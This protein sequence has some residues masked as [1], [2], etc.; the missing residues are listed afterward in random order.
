MTVW[1]TQL[2]R[3]IGLTLVLFAWAPAAR[4]DDGLPAHSTANPAQIR[5][6]AEAAEKAGD[7]EAAFAAYCQLFVT[8]RSLEVRER[9]NT[10]L[11]RVQQ[12][13]RHRDP[14]FARFVETLPVGDAL[15]L[16]AEMATK[17]PVMHA[18][19][20]RSAPQQ[21][22]EN[23]IEELDRALGS[24]AFRFGFLDAPSTVKVEAFRTSLRTHWSKR[25]VT[26]AKDAKHALRQLLA[27]A[28]DTFPLRL[29][30]A[31]AVEVL[32]GAC[33]GLDEYSVFLTPGQFHADP[34]AVVD[35]TAHGLYLGFADGGLVIDGIAAGSWAALHTV[36][37][38]GDRI[39]RLNGRSMDVVGPDAAADALRNHADGFHNLDIAPLGYDVA[40]QFV[41]LPVAV[42][43]V[44]GETILSPKD[45]IGYVR[46]GAF[47]P[48]TARELDEKITILQNRG[49]RALI[50][51]IR[52]NHGGSFLAG[53][54]VARRF[55]PAGIIVTTQGQLG[56][57]ANRVFSSDSG[58]AA[59]DLPV[60][61]LVDVETASAA[62]VFAVALK[63]NNRATLVGMPT[64]GKGSVLY[65]LKLAA[66]DDVDETGKPR[67][68]SG[69]V[70]LT[71]ARLLSPRGVPI[72]GSG[73]VPHVL[74]ADP[75]RQLDVAIS[76]AMQLLSPGMRPL[77][78]IIPPG[79]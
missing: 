61:V 14:A 49:L 2:G 73:I 23:G 78:P 54:D 44:F 37:Q 20:D 69:S 29:P 34:N 9:L 50:L 38:K 13:R 12:S 30:A 5:A 68:K 40:T 17:I 24:P 55:L 15:N 59:H 4:A 53:V 43:T 57:V 46:V 62:E 42:P 60:V 47:L 41:R 1:G 79:D 6:A 27:A 32:C 31:L 65:P 36:L 63:D 33:S 66:A 52:G 71:I 16:F 72:N 56:E 76:Q 51:D 11:R 8:D 67:E 10:A 45:G 35:L 3:G 7:W 77:M 18:D 48:T 21:L 19:R 74:E 26:T 64:F 22:W 25:V 75:A 58:M 70:R 28:A 39:T